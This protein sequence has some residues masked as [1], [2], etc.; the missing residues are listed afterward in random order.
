[1]SQAERLYET[2]DLYLASAIEAMGIRPRGVWSD[3]RR[4]TW[5]FEDSEGLRQIVADYFAWK[6]MLEAHGFA[7]RI[8]SAKSAA[9]NAPQRIER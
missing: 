2:E 6:L 4:S 7:E 9:K 5:E 3:G 8:R 1:M